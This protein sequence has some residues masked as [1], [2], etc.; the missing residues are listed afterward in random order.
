M[1]QPKK[2]NIDLKKWQQ[3]EYILKVEKTLSDYFG[4]VDAP[5]NFKSNEQLAIAVILSAQCTDERVNLVTKKF[6]KIFP[7]MKSLAKAQVSEVEELIFSTGF[8]HNKA[9]NIL[10]LAKILTA[11]Y[12]GKIP[13][14]FDTLVTLPG[15]GRKSANVIMNVAFSRSVGIVVD[16]HVR[17]ISQRLGFTD[18]KTPEKVEK[19]LMKVCPPKVWITLP[20]LLIFLGRK[21]CTSRSP[22]CSICILKDSCPQLP[23]DGKP[24]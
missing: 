22:K 23:A 7:D 1:K 19:D 11:K 12:H 24:A 18:K 5:L 14:D 9:K 3:H 15:I 21:F 2:N 6:F 10:A 17:R 4:D 16:T 8:Y 20:L 13:N